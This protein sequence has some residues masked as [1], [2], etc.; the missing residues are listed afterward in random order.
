MRQRVWTSFGYRT[1]TARLPVRNGSRKRKS[2]SHL[3]ANQGRRV[4]RNQSK[5]KKVK[6]QN[7]KQISRQF[8]IQSCDN[9][10][11]CVID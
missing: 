6:T 9:L 11:V 8:T 5:S 2:P 1:F 7:K 3:A 10:F 4:R